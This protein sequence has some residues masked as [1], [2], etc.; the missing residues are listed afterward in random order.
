V[1]YTIIWFSRR[2]TIPKRWY[3]QSLVVARHDM[4]LN[5]RVQRITTMDVFLA[6]NN[7]K[8]CL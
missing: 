5:Q 4:T 2:M 6:I 8:D 3:W 7:Y 1:G